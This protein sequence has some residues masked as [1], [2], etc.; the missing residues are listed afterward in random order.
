MKRVPV[1]S[2]PAESLSSALAEKFEA[3][4]VLSGTCPLF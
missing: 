4:T 1:S 3:D 2:A